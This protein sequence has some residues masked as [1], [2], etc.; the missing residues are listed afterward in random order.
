MA[1]TATPS[2][3]VTPRSI[4]AG[5][6]STANT[7]RDGTGTVATLAAGVAAGTRVNSVTITA[8]ATTTA[9]MVR[10]YLSTDTGTTWRLIK[11]LPVAAVTPSA[12][13]QAWSSGPMPC[14][15]YPQAN[16][17]A[18]PY[19]LPG[20]TLTGTSDLLGA[21]THNAEAFAYFVSAADFT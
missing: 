10:I 18:A 14:N 13:V 5:S 15:D 17:T 4:D 3:A 21:S 2:F 20:I 8:T 1:I 11:E 12:T 9:G 7:N 16:A 19:Y 6:F